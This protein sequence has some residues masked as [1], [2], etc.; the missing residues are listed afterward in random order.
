MIGGLSAAAN[1]PSGA[2]RPDTPDLTTI[3]GAFLSAQLA[4]DSRAAL[5]VVASA[6][7]AQV[8]VP[9]LYIDVI[10]WAQHRIGELWQRNEITVA[11]EHV[12]TAISQ[13]A[14]AQ[15]YPV[16][17]RTPQTG[18]Q[19]FVA[20][21]EGEQH[22]LGARMLADFCEMAG[23]DTRFAGANVPTD[24]LVRMVDA[25]A[26][27]IVALSVTMSFNL[28]SL[29][30]AVNGIR[31]LAPDSLSIVAGGHALI[32]HGRALDG[33]PVTVSTADARAAVGQ[34]RVDANGDG[35]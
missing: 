35:R 30:R 20:C 33:L 11:Q 5:E 23:F 15:L 32:W 17:P 14:L 22:E 12:A 34:L 29:S 16:L 1:G 8:P 6:V 18:R 9:M 27:D 13:L 10:G 21:V 31:A 2:L 19:V 26:P 7:R 3:A 25:A 24:S 28:P 4:P